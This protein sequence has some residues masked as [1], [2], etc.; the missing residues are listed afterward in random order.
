[1][2][3]QTLLE[4]LEHNNTYARLDFVDYSSDFN[5]I[6]PYNPRS[7]LHHLGL[8]T[9]LCNR[10]VDFLTN[11]TQ[12]VRVGKNTSSTLTINTGAPRGCVLSPLLYTLYTHDCLTSSASNLIVKFADD[13]TVLGLITNDNE[14][15]YRSEVQHLCHGATTTT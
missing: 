15:D 13:T 14:S 9:A 3:L 1:M 4:H 7:K 12:S 6:R 10:I 2:V 5:T 11:R 8:N